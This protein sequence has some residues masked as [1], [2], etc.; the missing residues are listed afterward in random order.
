MCM[1]RQRLKVRGNVSNL[2][3]YDH[4]VRGDNSRDPELVNSAA[5]ACVV[6][7]RR[8]PGSKQ[9]VQEPHYMP[10]RLLYVDHRRQQWQLVDNKG[11]HKL[12]IAL[13]YNWGND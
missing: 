8:S 6:Y 11:R 3:R 9:A 7:R 5:S 10:R 13:S 12:Y 1:V 4:R 2:G